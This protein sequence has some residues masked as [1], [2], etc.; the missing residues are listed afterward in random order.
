MLSNPSLF[1][2]KKVQYAYLFEWV[3]YSGS[4]GTKKDNALRKEVQEMGEGTVSRILQQAP[5]SGVDFYLIIKGEELSLPFTF[6]VCYYYLLKFLN[7]LPRIL[8]K[9][10]VPF[11]TVEKDIFSLIS[12]IDHA[13]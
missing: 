8:I 11:T 5:Y 12:R 1:S 10:T 4:E 7:V 13:P 6:Y 9:L 2:F 3:E